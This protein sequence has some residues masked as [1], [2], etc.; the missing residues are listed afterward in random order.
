MKNM[1]RFLA[2]LAAGLTVAILPV[3][4][5]EI[6]NA[7]AH[8]TPAG[9]EGTLDEVRAHVA[10]YP[11]WVL[12]AAAI[13]WGLGAFVSTRVGHRIGGRWASSVI[14]VLLVVATVFH[15]A[16]LPYALWFKTVI[17]P[18]IVLSSVMANPLPAPPI[19]EG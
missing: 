14:T 1:L 2:A 19:Q 7:L 8:P 12:A 11:H 18:L 13:A 6:L 15:I 9:F 16:S 5:V 3:V 4:L 10:R 17:V